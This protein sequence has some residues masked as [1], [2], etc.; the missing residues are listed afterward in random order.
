MY[1]QKKPKTKYEKINNKKI[2]KGIFSKQ[3]L[4]LIRHEIMNIH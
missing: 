2:D 4:L 1:I 3:I